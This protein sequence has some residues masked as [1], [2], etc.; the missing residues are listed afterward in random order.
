MMVPKRIRLPSLRRYI[1]RLLVGCSCRCNRIALA[2]EI[3]MPI[4]IRNKLIQGC[5][6]HHISIQTMDWEA[7]IQFY[8]DV[9]GMEKVAEFGSPE[10][11]IVLLD[12]GDG[13][14]VELLAPKTDIPLMNNSAPGM[15]I[16]HLALAVADTRVAIEHVREAGYLIT[17]EPRTVNLSGMSVT[18][19]FFKGPNGEEIEFFQTHADA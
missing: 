15:P 7:S 10:R 6:L 9:L 14:H 3:F 5:G 11:P 4:G 18:I 1:S 8:Q 2:K 16:A 19:A 13:S 17:T 12:I